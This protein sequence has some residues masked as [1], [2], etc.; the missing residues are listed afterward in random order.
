MGLTQ[1][2]VAGNQFAS[3]L[4][5]LLYP[6]YESLLLRF[7]GLYVP[8]NL[9]KLWIALSMAEALKC[10]LFWQSHRSTVMG[11]PYQTFAFE[12]LAAFHARFAVVT[13]SAVSVRS[14]AD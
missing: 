7:E 4:I 13:V 8:R 6:V 12:L 10:S 1:K 9:A 5:A 14:Q 3:F 2:A 11:T